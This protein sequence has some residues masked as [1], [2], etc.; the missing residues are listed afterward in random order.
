MFFKSLIG[1]A[2]IDVLSVYA[3]VQRTF[4]NDMQSIWTKIQDQEFLTTCGDWNDYISRLAEPFKSACNG[5]LIFMKELRF[6]SFFDLE[7]S[8]FQ[9]L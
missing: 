9:K 5:W 2:V 6:A 7:I 3:R 1:Q 4:S 8:F